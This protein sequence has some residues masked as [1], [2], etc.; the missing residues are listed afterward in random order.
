VESAFGKPLEIQ[1]WVKQESQKRY[2]QSEKEEMLGSFFVE[3]NELT[4][5]RNPRVVD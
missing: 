3:L 2:L 4:K 1:F 5:R